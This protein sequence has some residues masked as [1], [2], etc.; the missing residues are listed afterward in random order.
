MDVVKK[1]EKQSRRW[2]FTYNNP[3]MT[4]DDLLAVITSWN[5]FRYV[6][7]QLEEADTGTL[8]F[9][10]Y[11]EVGKA[12]RMSTL[13]HRLQMSYRTAKGSAEQ[14]RVYC[15]KTDT[16]IEGTQRTA[17]EPV[18]QGQRFDLIEFRDDSKKHNARWM[19]EEYPVMMA[20]FSKYF[21][22]CSGLH[23]NHHHMPNKKV[24][25]CFGDTDT[26]K[27]KWA[28]EYG[29]DYWIQPVATNAWF[30]GYDLHK[31]AIFDDYGGGGT[32]FKLV[33]LLRLT[34]DW[35]ETIPIKGGFA[36]WCPEVIIFT[37]NYLPSEWYELTGWYKGKYRDR[38]IS[39]RAL[40]RRF[41]MVYYFTE[42]VIYPIEEGKIDDFFMEGLPDA[43]FSD[44]LPPPI[45][46]AFDL[47]KLATEGEEIPQDIYDSQN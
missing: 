18:K 27:T 3:K 20:R 44:P 19:I 8:H 25:L 6:V 30:D 22:L 12:V 5:K 16:R 32:M 15:T 40:A 14:N 45:V 28:R 1:Y 7:F 47:M 41:T 9:Q 11:L 26:G 42:N 38:T 21:V 35:T 46:N 43:P 13:R 36:Q 39:Y 23:P 34:H 33:D 10:G 31:I 37:S 29:K 2:A 24:I 4:A 17:G